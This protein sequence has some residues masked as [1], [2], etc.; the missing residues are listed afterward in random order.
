MKL[1]LVRNFTA[2]VIIIGLLSACNE[3]PDELIVDSSMPQGT[4]EADVT[5]TFVEQ[6][7]TGSAGMAALG[8][9]TEGTSFLMFGSDFMTNLGTGTVTVFLSKTK[10]DLNTVFNPGSGNTEVKLVGVV[11]AN[12]QQYYKLNKKP[13]TEFKY[14]ILWCAS[15]GIPFG[16]A[17]LQ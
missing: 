16:Y 5:G 6:N 10:E 13:S 2:V 12:G 3:D 17:E 1:N 4:F 14:V 8:A 15:A 7:D 11:Q 9:D